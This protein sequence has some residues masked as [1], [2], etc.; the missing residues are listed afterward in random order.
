[1]TEAGDH[2]RHAEDIAALARNIAV[3][4]TYWLN[5][6]SIRASSTLHNDSDHLA[7]GVYQVLSLVAPFLK[8]EARRLLAADQPRIPDVISFPA[9]PASRSVLPHLAV[10]DTQSCN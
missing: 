4:A 3:V 7:L 1:L 10:D 8:G 6:Q 2:E 9:D 5:F